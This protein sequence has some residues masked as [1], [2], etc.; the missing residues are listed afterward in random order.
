MG[1]RGV[2]NGVIVGV[3]VGIGLGVDVDV[4]AGNSRPYGPGKSSRTWSIPMS[5]TV[6]WL[7]EEVSS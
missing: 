4:A 7:A 1:A 2:G 6:D 3:D 5:D